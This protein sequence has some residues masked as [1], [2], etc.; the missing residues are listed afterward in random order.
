M[1]A[2]GLVQVVYGFTGGLTTSV[3]AGTA[4]I[5]R[6]RAPQAIHRGLLS[7][8]PLE[9]DENFGRV[10]GAGD[11][12]NDNGGCASNSCNPVDLLVGSVNWGTFTNDVAALDSKRSTGVQV[13]QTEFFSGLAGPLNDWL[14]ASIVSGRLGLGSLCR[15]FRRRRLGK[16]QGDTLLT[17][18]ERQHVVELLQRSLGWR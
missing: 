12:L 15:R 7:A 13:N 10:L 17:L 5:D 1:F 18:L 16:C 11:F 6:W 8:A 3:A 9:S 4:N 2:A 14:D